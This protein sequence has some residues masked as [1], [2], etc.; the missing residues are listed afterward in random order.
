MVGLENDVMRGKSELVMKEKADQE[1]EL[2]KMMSRLK[3]CSGKN[4]TS[5]DLEFEQS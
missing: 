1:E 2:V 4:C 3:I 5:K